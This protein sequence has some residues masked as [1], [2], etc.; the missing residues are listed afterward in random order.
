MEDVGIFMAFCLLYVQME[1]IFYGHL[2]HFVVI[3]YIFIP[4]WYVV[5]S[6]ILQPRLSIYLVVPMYVGWYVW[7]QMH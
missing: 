5:P 3:W 4:F 2:V 7:T 1:Y 6:N